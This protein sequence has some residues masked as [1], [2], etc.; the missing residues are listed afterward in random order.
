MSLCLPYGNVIGIAMSVRYMIVE[1]S[2]SL[3]MEVVEV[4][5]R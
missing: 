2:L 5:R 1:G 4:A 3:P